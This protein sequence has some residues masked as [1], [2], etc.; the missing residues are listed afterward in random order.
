[1]GIPPRP[2]TGA[3]VAPRPAAS[4]VLFRPVDGGLEVLLTRRPAHM[5]FGGDLWVFP[6]GAVDSGDADHRSAAVRETFEETGIAVDPAAL[7]PVSR[8]VTPSGLPVRFDA[9]FFAATVL[10]AT[11][12]TVASEE[13]A[14]SRWLRPAAALEMVENA[15][16]PM[17]LPT[18]VVLQQLQDVTDAAAVER[19]FAPSAGAGGPSEPRFDRLGDGLFGVEQPWAGGVEG[20]SSTGWIAG[21]REWIVIDPADPTGETTDSILDEARRA[22]AR[23]AGVALTDLDPVHQAG[24]ETLARGFG[25]PVV[26]GAGAARLAPYPVNELADGQAVPFGDVAMVARRPER[27]GQADRPESLRYEGPGWRIPPELNGVGSRAG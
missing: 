18:I 6:G 15:D 2:V 3:T 10:P 8:W 14:E 22:G 27:S 12:V 1:M 4:L 19:A 9:R 16:L 11:D 13:V 24:V 26:A 20:R 25:L 23:L 5:R 21:H 7:I 17:W